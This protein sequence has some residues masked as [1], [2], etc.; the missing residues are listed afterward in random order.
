MARPRVAKCRRQCELM[1]GHP[2]VRSKAVA[3]L[4]LVLVCEP[5]LLCIIARVFRGPGPTPSLDRT[6]PR[7]VSVTVNI[8]LRR[9][10]TD[11][12]KG[13]ANVALLAD[14]SPVPP[15]LLK[16]S[17]SSKYIRTVLARTPSAPSIHGLKDTTRTGQ[18]EER[19]ISLVRPSGFSSFLISM[20]IRRGHRS[21]K[22]PQLRALRVSESANVRM[23]SLF[24]RVI[25]FT[26]VSSLRVRGDLCFFIT[27][28]SGP[29]KDDSD[30]LTCP[31]LRDADGSTPQNRANL[32]A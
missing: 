2:I 5:H 22:T 10:C 26:A 4:H 9:L 7:Y 13:V 16:M 28:S 27:G 8:G 15:N 11:D 24:L 25:P 30:G 29:A 17:M 6:N 12:N 20:G 1:H 32:L 31:F 14:A 18:I 3:A 19:Q 23:G 21:S